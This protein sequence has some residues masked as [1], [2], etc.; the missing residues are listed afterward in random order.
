MLTALT[1]MLMASCSAGPE[2]AAPAT[3]ISPATDRNQASDEPV[4]APAQPTPTADQT[5]TVT[6]G[7]T[8]P[9]TPAVT[10]SGLPIPSIDL[11]APLVWYAP[12]MGSVDYPDLFTAPEQWSAARDRVDVFQFYGNNVS[13][14]PFDIGGDNVLDTFVDAQA[15]SQL[16]QWQIAV[17]LELGVIKFFECT[18]GPWADYAQLA[19]DNVE[20][21]GGRVSFISMD[22][23]LVGAQVTEGGTTCGLTMAETATVVRDFVD[24]VSAAHPDVLIG[25]IGAYPHHSVAELEEWIATLESAGARPAFFHLDVDIERV[26]VE[27]QNVGRDLRRLRDYCTEHGIPFGVILTSNWTQAGSDEDYFRSTLRWTRTVADAIGRPAHAIF[28]S[29]QGPAAS[30]F[31]EVPINL[32]ESGS[33]AFSHTRLILAGLDVLEP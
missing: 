18:A 1:V 16:H 23:P 2:P 12:N 19:V 29:W 26:R 11:A 32:P 8:T 31:H 10:A 3:P 6:A 21:N 30:G 9:A 24:Q 33:E 7:P 27:G 5:P 28:Q 14:T 15:F 13:G 22:E 17:S 25:D 4:P 20:A